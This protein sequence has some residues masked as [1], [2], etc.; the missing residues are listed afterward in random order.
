M[1]TTGG[2]TLAYGRRFSIR[3]GN[4]PENACAGVP[5]GK[6]RRLECLDDNEGK[7]S[8]RCKEALRNS[9]LK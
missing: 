3:R 2:F 9:D 8:R 4:D 6:G 5:E 1:E 7:V